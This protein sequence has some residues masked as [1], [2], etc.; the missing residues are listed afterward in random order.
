[1]SEVTI[2]KLMD[3]LPRVFL[4]EKAA[5]I[6][7]V[8]HFALDG[9]KGGDWTVIIRDGAIRV[10]PGVPAEPATLTLHAKAQDILDI[11]TGKLDAASAFMQG[12]LRVNGSLGL[13][14]KL[15]GLFRIDAELFRLIQ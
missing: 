14:I 2:Q 4:P 5:G 3:A 10:A 8:A 7:A 13:A 12:R 9:E 11:F 15:S 6:D 1:M